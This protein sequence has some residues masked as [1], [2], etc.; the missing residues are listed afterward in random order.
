MNERKTGWDLVPHKKV[1]KLRP[2][3]V[4]LLVLFFLFVVFVLP[5]IYV[6]YK[7]GEATGSISGTVYYTGEEEGNIVVNAVQVNP[8]TRINFVTSV[9]A[10]QPYNLYGITAGNYTI[11][12]TLDTR[13][14]GRRNPNEPSVFYDAFYDANEDG[15]PDQVF[16]R[17][18]ITGIDITLK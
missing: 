3:Q 16:I 7:T 11:E 4:Y 14:N 8:R 6:L 1:K 2:S 9:I 13:F 17:G 5:S 10:N 15:E 12:A 18:K